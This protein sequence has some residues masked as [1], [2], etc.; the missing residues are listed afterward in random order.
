VAELEFVWD[1]IKNNSTSSSNSSP[2][3]D[4]TDY[5]Q[6]R[7]FQRPQSGSDGPM[8]VLSPMSQDDEDEIEAEK[9]LEHEEEAVVE[10]EDYKDGEY[11]GPDKE[12]RR[13]KRWRRKVEATL[14]KM[15]AEMAALREQIETGRD[16]RIRRQRSIGAWIGW[17]IWVTLRH[18]L[19]D[20]VLLGLVLLWMRK[21]KDRRLEDLVR[22]GLRIGREYIQKLLPPR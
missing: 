5:S 17:L 1:Q 13:I 21:R 16:W 8:K 22:Q 12:K 14:L 7:Q 9:R 4:R 3:R 10:G 11:D 6:P 19:L 18:F 2:G 15:T 20:A